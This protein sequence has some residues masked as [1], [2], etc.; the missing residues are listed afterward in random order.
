MTYT[1]IYLIC[2]AA[3]CYRFV[4]GK[5]LHWPTADDAVMFG[6]L[7]FMILTWPFF[8]LIEFLNGEKTK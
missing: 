2:G 8:A 3:F 6:F 4:F 1:A 5:K 7:C